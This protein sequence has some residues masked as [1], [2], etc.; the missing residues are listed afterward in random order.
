MIYT[1]IDAYFFIHPSVKLKEAAAAFMVRHKIDE[2]E[3]SLNTVI[4]IYE[5]VSNDVIDA[6]RFQQR[7][8]TAG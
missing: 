3:Y 4:A 6:K 5:R 1:F 2:D 8:A 7:Q